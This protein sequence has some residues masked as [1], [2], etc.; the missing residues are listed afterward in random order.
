MVSFPGQK[1]RCSSLEFIWVEPNE[2][3]G[4]WELVKP[5]LEKV[6]KHGGGWLNEDIYASI[7]AGQSNLHVFYDDATY[8]GFVLITP[9]V[10]FGGNVLHV[11]AMYSDDQNQQYH[12]EVNNQLT[13]WAE[14][15]KAKTIT[16]HTSRKGWGKVGEKLGFKAVMT[17]YERTV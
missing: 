2:I 9:S 14:S 16:F 3:H 8:V 12:D 5:G 15:M 10:G 1:S 17:I 13:Q 6:K 4:Y 7:K 11:W